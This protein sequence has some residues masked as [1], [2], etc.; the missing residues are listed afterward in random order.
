MLDAMQAHITPRRLSRAEYDRMAELG[1][2]RNERV[3]LIRGMVVKMTPIGPPHASVVDRLNRLFVRALGE[4]ALVRIQQPLI[5]FDESEPEPD[6]AVVPG[7]PRD[8]VAAHPSR[9]H[10]VPE[11]LQVGRLHPGEQPDQHRVGGGRDR[12]VERRARGIE[13]QR[14]RARVHHRHAARAGHERHRLDF[15]HQHLERAGESPHH[16]TR[17]KSSH[18]PVPMKFPYGLPKTNPFGRERHAIVAPF[19]GLVVGA[20][21]LPSV[22]PGNAVVHIV[23]LAKSLPRIEAVLDGRGLLELAPGELSP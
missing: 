22:S 15:A 11:Q 16:A 6:V 12:Q 4:R 1:F 14:S 9:G 18:F 19:T 13:R 5:A 10:H 20:T 21:T 8:Y 23:K 3:E 7:S 17:A 2:F